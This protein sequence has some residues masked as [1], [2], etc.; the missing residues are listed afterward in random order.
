MH[1]SPRKFV[2]FALACVVTEITHVAPV[3]AQEITVV[4]TPHLTGLDPSPSDEQFAN[5][6]K[7]LGQQFGFETR[8]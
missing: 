8:D 1:F 7:W 5:A 4:G 6:M 2:V 3:A